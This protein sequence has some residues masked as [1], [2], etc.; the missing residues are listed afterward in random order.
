MKEH[1]LQEEL[2]IIEKKVADSQN[3]RN[4]EYVVNKQAL[5]TK[6]F[7]RLL[8][9]FNETTNIHSKRLFWLTVVMA[10]LTGLLTWK[11]FCP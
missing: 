5:L 11:T 1:E 7:I 3:I 2:K 4:V 8:N 10:A 9:E 6:L